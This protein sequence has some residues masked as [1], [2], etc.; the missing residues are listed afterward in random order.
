[1]SPIVVILLIFGI[2]TFGVSEQHST[3]AYQN[4][5]LK[6]QVETLSKNQIPTVTSL[7]G[8]HIKN[9]TDSGDAQ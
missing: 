1:M 7:D 5:E 8:A 4:K 2:G 3:L 6:A 9:L